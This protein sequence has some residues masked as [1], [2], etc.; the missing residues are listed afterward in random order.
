[1]VGNWHKKPSQQTFCKRL[2]RRVDRGTLVFI[3]SYGVTKRNNELFKSK[4]YSVTQEK[5]Q[6][7]LFFTNDRK[8][9]ITDH[10]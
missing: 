2:N 10:L 7:P 4:I 3:T 5:A 8:Y 6:I 9:K 1:M